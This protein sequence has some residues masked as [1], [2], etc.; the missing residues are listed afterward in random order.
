MPSKLIPAVSIYSVVLSQF[1][2]Y[3][4]TRTLGVCVWHSCIVYQLFW[5][6]TTVISTGVA[7]TSLFLSVPYIGTSVTTGLSIT[8]T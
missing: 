6:N 4:D 1:L 8:I 3:R 2:F 5:R 7:S